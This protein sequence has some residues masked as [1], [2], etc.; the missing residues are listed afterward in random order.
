MLLV[1][2][3]H[4]SLHSHLNFVPPPPQ[5]FLLQAPT[6]PITKASDPKAPIIPASAPTAHIVPA[7]ATPQAF[8]PQPPSVPII[9]SSVYHHPNPSFFSPPPPQSVL[10]QPPTVPIIL[11]SAPYHPNH[12]C[13]SCPLS[14]LLAS[15]RYQMAPLIAMPVSLRLSCKFILAYCTTNFPFGQTVQQVDSRSGR[16][17]DDAPKQDIQLIH[18]FIAVGVPTW[19]INYSF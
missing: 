11:A 14:H 4:N 13:F 15:H 16:G 2:P 10:P 6:V 1:L 9:L 8:L 12:S 7:S 19:K 3:P 18:N 5:S 17:S